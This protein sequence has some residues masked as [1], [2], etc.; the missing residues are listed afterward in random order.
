[1]KR[2]LLFRGETYYPNGGWEDFGGEFDSVDEAICS[3]DDRS[4]EYSFR[5]RGRV[6]SSKHTADWAHVVDASSG[7]V[8][9]EAMLSKY[10]PDISIWKEVE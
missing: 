10:G 4:Y 1:M 6:F 3:M 9:A 8:V 7:K 5:E 2:Y